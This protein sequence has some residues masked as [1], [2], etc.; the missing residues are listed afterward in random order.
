MVCSKVPIVREGY[1]S[2]GPLCSTSGT[3]I[4][5]YI[6]RRTV[7]TSAILCYS[8]LGSTIFSE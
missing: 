8:E 6:L 5:L 3:D 7:M 2:K 1:C 4:V